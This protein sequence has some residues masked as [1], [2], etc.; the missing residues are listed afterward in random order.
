MIGRAKSSPASRLILAAAVAA[1]LANSSWPV[2]AS[3][4][5]RIEIDSRPV[6]RF[7]I[8]DDGMR[9]GPLEFVAGLEM[10]SPA[11]DFGSLS[12]FRFLSP[13]RDFIGV[14]DTGYWFFG[15]IER[16]AGKRP[17]GVSD[18]RMTPVADRAGRTGSEK[19]EIDAEGLEVEDGIAIVGFERRHRISRYRIDPGGMGASLGE[20]DFRVPARE[21]RRN[22]G[23]ETVARA[24]AEGALPG[25]LVVVSEKSLDESGNIFAAIVEGPGTG[26]F[27]VRR[28][29]DFDITDGAFL[30][31][32]DLLILERSFSMT[33]GVAM[34]LR[35]LQAASIVTGK[36]AD[37]PVLVEA[38][39]SYQIDNMEGMA[40]WRRDD[41]A[42]MVSL[43]SDD[44]HSLL[45]R[46]LYLE[47]ILHQD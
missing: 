36:V 18:F 13:G 1:A 9:F 46:S 5:E 26:V 47:F 31:G 38:N 4:V 11:G 10:T 42:L 34:R 7:R 44:N 33:S 3:P 6:S 39:M 43:I 16:D 2:V 15:T 22:R 41:G 14:T 21:L 32:G 8:G 12:A 20:I 45:Q 28:D 27:T 17:V 30:P 25:R 19:S 35:R 40:V 29:R 37:G 24:P 23:F